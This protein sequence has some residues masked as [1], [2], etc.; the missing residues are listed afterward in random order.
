[1]QAA[2]ETTLQYAIWATALGGLSAVSLPLGSAT[3]LLVKPRDRTTS[4][5]AA[6][7]GGAL[8]AALSVELVAPS[9]MALSGHGGGHGHGGDPRTN[10]IALVIGALIGGALFVIL[11]QIVNAKGGFLRKSATTIAYFSK[12]KNERDVQ[13][14]K[15]LSTVPMLCELPPKQ[16]NELVKVVRL[17]HYHDGEKIFGEGDEGDE[18]FFIRDGQVSL[19]HDGH[20]FKDLGA[21]EVLGEIALLTGA[22]RT[23]GAKAKGM[24]TCLALSKL[25]FDQLREKAPEFDEA[26]RGLAGERL[27]E[28][29]ATRQRRM[30]ASTG[31]AKD[32]AKALRTGKTIPTASDLLQARH[33]HHGAPLAIWLGIMLDGIPE[34]FVIGAAFLSILSVKLAESGGEAIAFTSII[35]YTL[36]AGLFLANF[37]EA[38]SSSIGMKAQGYGWKRIL[39]MWSSLMILTAVGAGIGYMLGGAVSHT[40]VVGIEGLAAGAMLTMIASAMIPEAVHLGSANTVGLSTLC[41]FLSALM[42]KLFE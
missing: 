27:D 20:A 38:M 42:F 6:F 21:G 4:A 32:A 14:L 30:E 16:V 18:M 2:A 41:G 29:S 35:P 25:D 24:T 19:V 23:A 22:P 28:L 12:R 11:D 10:F 15:D 13:M 5:M 40:I 9:V 33:A 26:M 8:L 7:G 39:I 1:M 31:W 17:E 37:P 3:G 34:S 36:M